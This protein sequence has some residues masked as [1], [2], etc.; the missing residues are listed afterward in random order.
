MSQAL[1]PIQK[2]RLKL[3]AKKEIAGGYPALLNY[4]QKIAIDL[5]DSGSPL[6]Y[7]NGKKKDLIFSD[8]IEKRKNGDINYLRKIV[9]NNIGNNYDI[10]L[11]QSIDFCLESIESHYEKSIEL[12]KQRESDKTLNI[13]DPFKRDF[14]SRLQ[15]SLQK[16]LNSKNLLEWLQQK[17][18]SYH[19][20]FDDLIP[21]LVANPTAL[22]SIIDSSFLEQ[23]DNRKKIPYISKLYHLK[24]DV[25]ADLFIE[26]EEDF[27]DYYN[28]GK[29][30]ENQ[31]LLEFNNS[32]GSEGIILGHSLS[33]H[34][35]SIALLFDLG[36][37][38]RIGTVFEKKM[39][40]YLTAP[41]WAKN[42]RTAI[43]IEENV[44]NRIKLLEKSQGFRKKLYKGLKLNFESVDDSDIK[45]PYKDISSAKIQKSAQE[46]SEYAKEISNTISISDPDRKI[47]L[48]N[49]IENLCKNE[50]VDSLYDNLPERLK[51]LALSIVEDKKNLFVIHTILKHFNNLEENTFY[52][53]LL[54]RYQQHAYKNWIKIGVESERK[55]DAAF[56]KMDR[57]EKID[58]AMGGMYYKHYYFKKRNNRPLNVIPY[59]FPSGRLWKDSEQDIEKAK[60]DAILLWDFSDERKIKIFNL[61]EDIELEQ[62]AIQMAD[63]FSFCHFFFEEEFWVGDKTYSGLNSILSEIDK[64]CCKVWD[65]YRKNK[66][67]SKDFQNLFLTLLYSDTEIPYYFYPY[68]HVIKAKKD[69]D[70]EAIMRKKYSEIYIYTLTQLNNKLNYQEW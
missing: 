17:A 33:I 56:I 54:Q 47:K 35:E 44:A 16:E 42:N 12:K 53:S 60:S 70:F 61:I 48:L 57:V 68:L 18:K 66:N 20:S 49:F 7:N 58:F 59:T 40:L 9:E 62:L 21:F 11:I 10:T 1:N 27:D 64:N 6:L 41:S 67:A 13:T 32:N 55:F 19:L 15:N 29:E 2:L 52:Y 69:K 63:L 37:F 39:N 36:R 34:S 65:Y 43:E 23:D 28:G 26:K 22:F 31:N 8:Y 5:T 46:F 25:D 3:E 38:K 30:F 24:T 51:L 4:V 50:N 45:S 14:Y